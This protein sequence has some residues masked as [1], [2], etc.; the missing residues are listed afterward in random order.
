M[1]LSIPEGERPVL[2]AELENSIGAD[3]SSIALL[4]PEHHPELAAELLARHDLAVRIRD[5]LLGDPPWI[6]DEDRR[7][8]KLLLIRYRDL[9]LTS[10]S[11]KG[12]SRTG[13]LRVEIPE[14]GID[15]ELAGAPD[16]DVI[17]RAAD[18]RDACLDTI[19]MVDRLLA[20]LAAA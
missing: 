8:L 4:S 1:K 19:G 13:P 11:L 16:P 14:L 12:R 3:D 7:D 10:L 17:R 15:E 9:A 5:V 18:Y 20:R 6:I 2:L